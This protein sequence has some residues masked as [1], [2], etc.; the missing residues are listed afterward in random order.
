MSN[1]ISFGYS[2]K[3]LRT[4]IDEQNNVWFVAKDVC[5]ILGISWKG[6]SGTLKMIPDEWRGVCLND[7]PLVNQHG[8][9]GSQEQ[10]L[11]TINQAGLFKLVF[12]S[13]KPE[14]EKFTNWVASDVLPALN[15]DGF[16]SLNS[17]YAQN[18]KEQQ[19]IENRNQIIKELEMRVKRISSTSYSYQ[20][21]LEY[22][23]PRIKNF[24]FDM[25]FNSMA[26]QLN[27]LNDF[28]TENRMI[29]EDNYSLQ[30]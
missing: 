16:Y 28:M 22:S 1:L 14:A 17:F 26:M 6:T 20:K 21:D 30:R 7:T 8:K 12:R 18:N 23:S 15:K 10:E 25:Y 4:T 9:Y 3:Q 24:S 27:S 29:L 19:A 2:E 11:V 13:N 5:D